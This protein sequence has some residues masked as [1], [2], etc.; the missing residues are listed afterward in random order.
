MACTYIKSLHMYVVT[1]C[2][3]FSISQKS[4]TTPWQY[5]LLGY[6]YFGAQRLCPSFHP[7]YTSFDSTLSW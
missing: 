7:E 1:D 3:W 4:P 6:V 5:F 2:E